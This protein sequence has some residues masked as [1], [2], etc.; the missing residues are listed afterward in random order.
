MPGAHS[1]G[2]EALPQGASGCPLGGIGLISVWS[3]AIGYVGSGAA[4]GDSKPN[5]TISPGAGVKLL[6][7]DVLGGLIS[8]GGALV[9]DTGTVVLLLQR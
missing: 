6:I 3:P 1:N 4:P 5:V 8:G 9:N 2:N 7:G